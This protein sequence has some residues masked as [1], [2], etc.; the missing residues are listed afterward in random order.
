M[1]PCKLKWTAEE[2]AAMK[3]GIEK[4]GSGKWRVILKDPQFRSALH[5]RSNVD[6]KV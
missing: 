4:H 5:A 3:A 1:G 2:E 6:L